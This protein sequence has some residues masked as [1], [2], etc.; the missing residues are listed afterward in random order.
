[1]SCLIGYPISSNQPS[2]QI[3]KSNSKW[4][5][6]FVV[7]HLSTHIYVSVGVWICVFKEVRARM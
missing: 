1:M 6:C 5:H 4:T 7:M 2:K 3:Y